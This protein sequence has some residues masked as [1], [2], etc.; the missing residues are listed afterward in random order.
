VLE[1]GDQAPN[2]ELYDQEGN[3]WRLKDLQGLKV[4]LYFYPADDTPGCTRESCDFRD[5]YSE[6]QK[7]GYLVLGLSPQDTASKKAFAEKYKLPFPLLAD[8]GAEVAK[9]YDVFADGGLTW[10]ETPL[11]VKRSTFVIDEEGRIEQALYGVS[12]K[13]HVGELKELL[14]V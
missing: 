14:G 4:V 2:F 11:V 10:G 7:A 9:A 6:F 5:S 12:S 1:R 13:R 3:D 8:E